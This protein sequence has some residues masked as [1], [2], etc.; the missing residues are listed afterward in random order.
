MV[1]I[2]KLDS[3]PKFDLG[4]VTATPGV[5]EKVDREYAMGALARHLQADW[6]MCGD[7]DWQTND[8]ALAGGGRLLSVYP[9]PDDAGN[10]WIITEWDRT[11]TTMLL[12]EE[13]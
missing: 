3:P 5:M 1:K 7:E 9:L 12:P 6:G 10:F 4:A 8:D 2:L 13:Y 11:L